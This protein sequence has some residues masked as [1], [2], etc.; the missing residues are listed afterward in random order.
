MR[1]QLK[2]DSLSLHKKSKGKLS[3]EATVPVKNLTDLSLAY[4]PGVAFPCLEIEKDES[5]LYTYTS[6]SH[7]VAVITDGSAVLGLGNIGAKASLPVMEGK[8]VLFKEFAGIDA[9]PICIDTQ[10]EEEFINIVK[11]ISTTFGGIN[12]E[13]ISAPK[14]INIEK[15]LKK[16]LNIPVFHDDQHGTAI[17]VSAALINALKLAN[18]EIE[19]IKVVISG[20]GS[21]GN[22]I[23][24]LLY[25]LGA[26]N[27]VA[28]NKQGVVNKSTYSN[29]TFV[30]QDLLDDQIIINSPKDTLKD[31]FID[32]D[33]FIGVSAK[34]IVSKE[35]VSSMNSQPIIFALANPDPEI[36]YKDAVSAGAFIVGTGRSDYPNQINNVLAFPGIFKGALESRTKNITEEMKK[37]AAY[38]IADIIPKN[39]LKRDYIIP[40]AF[41]EKVVEAVSNAVKNCL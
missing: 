4:S 15:A 1:N 40:S 3:V 12:L 22:S 27:I 25:D 16:A 32:A 7:M 14:C 9:F 26:R 10:D 19:D 31:L 38:A 17:V 18:K 39:A 24:R 13:D 29:Q 28:Y 21:A 33:V 8:A 30:E 34:N 36:T 23:A 20:T 41:N 37:A 11:N 2:I 35:M 6:K 5:Q